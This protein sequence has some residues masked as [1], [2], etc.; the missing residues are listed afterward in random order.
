M[1]RLQWFKIN[2]YVMEE[3]DKPSKCLITT[4]VLMVLTDHIYI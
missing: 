3:I 4:L 2:I 1:V